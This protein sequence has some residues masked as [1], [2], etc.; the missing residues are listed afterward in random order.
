VFLCDKT[1]PGETQHIHLLIQDTD[2]LT[3]QSTDAN[4]VQHSEPVSFFWLLT[5]IWVRYF[6]RSRNDSKTAAS[7]KPTSHGW[8][9]IKS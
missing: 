5:G 9:L 2:P 4:K 1:F 7:P 6:Y 8:Q 3:D